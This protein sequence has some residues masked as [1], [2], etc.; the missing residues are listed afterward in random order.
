MHRCSRLV[1]WSGYRSLPLCAR[2]RCNVPAH[3]PPLGSIETMRNENVSTILTKAHTLVQM[4]YST[5]EAQEDPVHH[6]ILK[7][8][9]WDVGW[10]WTSAATWNMYRRRA[11]ITEPISEVLRVI[12]QLVHRC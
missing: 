2:Y 7:A 10:F 12:A 8:G 6:P 3:P 11:N 5:A 9:A 4:R 1:G